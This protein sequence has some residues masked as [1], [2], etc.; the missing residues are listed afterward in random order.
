MV[1]MK[2]KGGDEMRKIAD[3][4]LFGIILITVS[5]LILAPSKVSEKVV[6]NNN[7]FSEAAPSISTPVFTDSQ[8]ANSTM[9]QNSLSDLGT[10]RSEFTQSEKLLPL[11]S[12]LTVFVLIIGLVALFGL[13]LSLCLRKRRKRN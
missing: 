9:P 3:V 1:K 13:I 12:P 4:A 11:P 5:L 10:Q 2:T 7:I 8:V 6:A